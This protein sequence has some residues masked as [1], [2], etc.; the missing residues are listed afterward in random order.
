MVANGVW[1]HSG[2]G[3]FPLQPLPTETQFAPI[4]AV[5]AGDFAGDGHVD[6][7]VAGNFYG[8]PPVLGRYD[9][10]Y[11][12]L[13]RG[14]GDGRFEPVDM[15]ASNLVIEGEVRHMRLLRHA[16]GDRLIV[17]ARNDD[18]LQLLRPLHYRLRAE[19]SKR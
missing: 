12:L 2:K 10:G 16:G 17:A 15:A 3:S 7:L 1:L 11:G 6:L 8:V 13:L 18:K 4:Y 9:A 5:L 19:S 14:M